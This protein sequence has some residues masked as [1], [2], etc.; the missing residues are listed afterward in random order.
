MLVA[1]DEIEKGGAM[2]KTQNSRIRR[3]R[4]GKTPIKRNSSLKKCDQISFVLLFPEDALG[5][6]LHGDSQEVKLRDRV[7]EGAF[8]I[9]FFPKLGGEGDE[10]RVIDGVVADPARAN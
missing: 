5:S 2:G 9:R 4:R 6:T 1:R 8:R 3:M 7:D 10:A